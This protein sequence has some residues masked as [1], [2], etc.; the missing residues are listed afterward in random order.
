MFDI[1]FSE[2]VL[3]GVIALLVVG[4]EKLPQLAR[5]AGS[6]MGKIKRFVN[7]ARDDI[8]HELKP[9]ELRRV[10]NE[11]RNE[12]SQLKAMISSAQTDPRETGGSVK[13]IEARTVAH[14]RKSRAAHAGTGDPCEASVPREL[15]GDNN[16]RRPARS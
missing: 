16:A 1:G 2:L 10:L 5:Q 12:I 11:Q 3:I 13:K 7:S 15:I 6:W 8:E 4:P 14:A 9:D